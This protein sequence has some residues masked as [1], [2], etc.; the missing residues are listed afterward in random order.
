MRIQAS[1]PPATTR[2]PRG[3]WPMRDLPVIGWLLATIVVALVHPWL[4]APR[5][6]LIHLTL[7]GAVTH[8]I[9]VWS[10]YFTD[11]LLR[12][13]ADAT[14]GPQNARLALL[15][16][17]VLAVV[18]GVLT[19]WWPATVLGGASVLVAVAWHGAALARRLHAALSRRF[20]M[21]VRFYVAAAALFTV[22]IVIGVLVARV[23]ADPWHERLLVAHASTNLLGW[24]G[25][26]VLG[27]LVTLWPTMLRTRLADGVERAA[28]RALPVLLVAIAVTVAGALAGSPRASALGLACYLAGLSLLA[29]GFVAAARQRRPTSYAAASALGAVCWLVLCLVLLVAGFAVAADWAEAGSWFER[30]TPFLAAGFG[31]QVLLGAMSYLVPVALG[32]GPRAVATA[33]RAMDRGGLFRVGVVN[34]GLVACLVPLPAIVRV[35]CSVLV[36]AAL[37]SFLPLMMLAI[38]ASVTTRRQQAEEPARTPMPPVVATGNPLGALALACCLVLAAVA[39]GTVVDQ[40]LG[41]GAGSIAAGVAATGETTVVEVEARDMAFFPSRIEVPAGN[42]LVIEV[43]NTDTSEVHDLV[44]DDGTDSGR[45]APGES[46]RLE[47]AVVGRDVAG[48]CSVLG[49]R[50]MGMTLE[51]IAL[52]APVAPTA[53]GADG[54]T[55]GHGGHQHGPADGAPAVVDPHA[56]PDADFTAY[57]ATLPPLPEP[58][59]VPRVHRHTFRISDTVAEVAPG[60]TQTLWTYQGSAPG[61]T[62]HGRVGDRFEITLVNDGTVGH[63]IDFHAGALAPD[64]PMR[65]IP[66]GESLT[67]VFTATR[68]GIWMYHCGTMPMAAHIANGLFGAVVIEPADLTPV[69]RSWVLVQSE[70]YLGPADAGV[71]LAKVQAETPDLVVF[72]GYA[73]QYD[74]QPLTARVGERVRIWVLDAGPN[75]SSSFHVIGGQFDTVWLEGAYHLRQG[76]GAFGEEDGGSQAL[77]LFPAQGGFVE[78]TFDEAGHYPFVSHLMVDGERGAHGIV[79][80]TD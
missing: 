12:S 39:G 32:G 70:F 76:E 43:R 52:G 55:G 19:G 42:R 6:L 71:D 49:H 67:Y 61:P 46:A 17:G 58:T 7:L 77:G 23:Q 40:R 34:A 65:T 44:L 35:A 5:W 9:L 48:W 1:P 15:D 78:L 2:N 64:E 8:S 63:S 51:I 14:R 10:R 31:A 80:V 4:P 41:P 22:G 59:G 36:L 3:F 79:R 53:S 38:K 24:I 69:D 29:P 73:N 18:A 25:L 54:G 47:I 56:E 21:V 13:P 45:L 50:Q 20:A 66:P 60:V 11:T 57:D 27:T 30:F 62:L 72:N 16:L 37:A 68:A 28:R 74:H 33:T 75:R 26:T